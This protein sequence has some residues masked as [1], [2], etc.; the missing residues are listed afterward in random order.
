MNR[1]LLLLAAILTTG[2]VGGGVAVWRTHARPSAPS[3]ATPSASDAPIA[4]RLFREPTRLQNLTMQSLDGTSIST[5][6]LQ[7][8]VILVNFWATWCP[9]CRAE[10]PDLVALQERYRDHLQIIGIS[11]D[12]GDVS[13]VKAFAAEHHVNYPIVMVT[14]EIEQAFAGVSGLP[15]TFVIDRDGFV[16]QKHVGLLNAELTEQETRGLAGLTPVRIERVEP[17]Q[18]LGLDNAAQVKEIPGVDLASL[19]PAARATALQRLNAEACTCGCG[20]TVARCRVDD[21]SCGTSLP[22]AKEIVAEVAA[23]GP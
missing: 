12:E 9:P 1:P 13:V 7:G 5:A 21:P 11:E 14:P 18:A 10:M 20:L 8:K 3:A 15:T 23:S 17:E 4:L 2:V 16:V 22:R 19:S 6:N